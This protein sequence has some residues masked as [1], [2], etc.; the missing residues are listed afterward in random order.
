MATGHGGARAGQV[1]RSDTTTVVVTHELSCRPWRARVALPVRLPALGTPPPRPRQAPARGQR[2]RH[3]QQPA[4]LGH[5]WP[6]P[7]GPP[8]LAP[9][10][11]GLGSRPARQGPAGTGC[12]GG[13]SSA[14]AGP[15]PGPARS[16][17]PATER[18]KP[19]SSRM[20]IPSGSPKVSHPKARRRSRAASTSPST[21]ESSRCRRSGVTSPIASATCQPFSRSTGARPPA[22]GIPAGRTVGGA[23]G[24]GEAGLAP[25]PQVVLRGHPIHRGDTHP[26]RMVGPG[27]VR[28]RYQ[29][30]LPRPPGPRWSGG[31]SGAGSGWA[32]TRPEP[33][34][35]R[36]WD[37]TSDL[38]R[39]KQALSR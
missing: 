6:G 12:D 20:P 29:H 23:G 39:V 36:R 3:R 4:H 2:Q 26:A 30:H 38:L 5:P 14:S 37:R 22:G 13:T 33:A 28:S 19:L 18:R 24:E 17:L 35:G 25:A 1:D 16:P 32:R 34:G 10:R 15:P 9:P 27:Q 7:K 31:R 8:L 21:R 11:P